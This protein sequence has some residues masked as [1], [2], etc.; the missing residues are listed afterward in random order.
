[1]KSCI[2]CGEKLTETR[3]NKKYCQVCYHYVKRLRSN[4]SYFKGK[5]DFKQTAKWQD[6]LDDVLSGKMSQY[7][8]KQLL[9]VKH[10]EICQEEIH[11]GTCRKYCAKC[12]VTIRN[13]KNSIHSAKNLGK[14]VD[15]YK[16]RLDKYIESRKPVKRKLTMNSI[17]NYQI[18]D[19][20]S[21]AYLTVRFFCRYDAECYIEERRLNKK[22]FH[23]VKEKHDAD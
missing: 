2:V 10:C 16:Q 8:L 15:Y 7:E 1:M 12:S 6:M 14:N 22:Y 11:S 23:I 21:G 20:F 18:Y 5:E 19:S 13:F 3:G 17:G 9:D 4:I